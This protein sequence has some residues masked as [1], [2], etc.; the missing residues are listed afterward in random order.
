MQNKLR[1]V[2]H[3]V[4][5]AAA[6]KWILIICFHSLD[7]VSHQSMAACLEANTH[8]SFD[9]AKYDI[10]EAPLLWIIKRMYTYRVQTLRYL[11]VEISERRENIPELL[12]SCLLMNLKD[13]MSIFGE[14]GSTFPAATHFLEIYSAN[15]FGELEP[16]VHTCAQLPNDTFF[17]LCTF[18]GWAQ[19]YKCHE[20][21]SSPVSACGGAS[22]LPQLSF[23]ETLLQPLIAPIH[24][25]CNCLSF[26]FA[27]TGNL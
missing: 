14:R 11:H 4:S 24:S 1:A 27:Q 13:Q 6:Q 9:V 26:W 15:A 7:D 25:T 8:G 20:R 17:H 3:D 23:F 21:F 18:W 16:A 19:L 2:V 5:A 10:T 12:L 22:F